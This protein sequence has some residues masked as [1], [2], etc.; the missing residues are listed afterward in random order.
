MVLCCF[1]FCLDDKQ[2]T[3]VK[4]HN[5]KY[6][7]ESHV[8]RDDGIDA[9]KVKKP[10][11]KR[12]KCISENGLV[13]EDTCLL[14]TIGLALKQNRDQAN[15]NVVDK[16][17]CE[18]EAPVSKRVKK[19]KK[20]KRERNIS[21]SGLI[22]EDTRLPTTTSLNSTE[23]KGQGRETVINKIELKGNKKG[24]EVGE[25]PLSK[26]NKK[27]KKKG[28]EKTYNEI[29]YNGGNRILTTVPSVLKKNNDESSKIRT[30]NDL[31]QSNDIGNL[32]NCSSGKIRKK[33]KRKK[34]E[35]K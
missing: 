11:K 7:N 5:K 9:K 17:E 10:K 15:E 14:T 2:K 12:K 19:Q 28:K 29:V 21:E 35:M 23:N 31:L 33:K 22:K 27:Q 16:V 26:G 20:K 13:K 4:K 6:N 32:D 25:I 30:D 3:V 18:G 1:S 34:E 24:N 8:D